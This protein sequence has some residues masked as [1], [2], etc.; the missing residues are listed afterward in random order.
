MTFLSLILSIRIHRKFIINLVLKIPC[1]CCG[2]EMKVLYLDP[3]LTNLIYALVYP[4][5]TIVLQQIQ[6]LTMDL[7]ALATMK[8]A[9]KC[10]K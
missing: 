5:H 9:V 7:L 6:L 8:N 10:E 3:N 1:V 4:G 2:S